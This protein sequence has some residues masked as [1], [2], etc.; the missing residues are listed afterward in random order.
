MDESGNQ[1]LCS[2]RERCLSAEPQHGFSKT[3]SLIPAK[4]SRSC[5]PQ[6]QCLGLRTLTIL[7]ANSSSL[8]HTPFHYLYVLCRE[9]FVFY[10]RLSH[11]NLPVGE[12]GHPLWRSKSEIPLPRVPTLIENL[13][14]SLLR[15]SCLLSI[16]RVY[17]SLGIRP[18]LSVRFIS[19]GLRDCP[20][21]SWIVSDFQLTIN[22]WTRPLH[23]HVTLKSTFNAFCI[24]SFCFCML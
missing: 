20:V 24:A 18:L 3:I 15:V 2:I 14:P 17:S 6:I 10:K 19:K 5:V 8:P 21:Y 11:K 22:R 12:G 9:E 16:S 13:F 4:T 7:F 23:R 1:K